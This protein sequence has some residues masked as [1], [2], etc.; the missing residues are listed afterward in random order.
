MF[1]EHSKYLNIVKKLL[2][3]D[4]VGW[5]TEGN[6]KSLRVKVGVNEHLLPLEGEEI[7]EET[8]RDLI[9][10]ILA[11]PEKF[12]EKFPEDFEVTKEEIDDK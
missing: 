11:P 6:K 9:N 7:N 2:K 4:F 5:I 1:L 3:A 10:K 12:K 8:Y